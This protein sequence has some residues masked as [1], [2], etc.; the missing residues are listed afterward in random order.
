M[1]AAA[2]TGAVPDLLR[3]CRPRPRVHTPALIAHPKALSTLQNSRARATAFSRRCR[4]RSLRYSSSAARSAS[5][6]EPCVG[7]TQAVGQRVTPF[8]RMY[9]AITV[10]QSSVEI[11][12]INV[13]L[14]MSK[15]LAILAVV[16]DSGI[17][18]AT[19]PRPLMPQS[20]RELPR[21]PA[22]T[23][24]PV[25]KRLLWL[26]HGQPGIPTRRVAVVGQIIRSQ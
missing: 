5:V 1:P 7:T 4:S 9:S 21:H 11:I 8:V 15:P 6:T 23:T 14:A 19:R 26:A 16:P 25:S 10:W 24:E 22:K 12:C 20:P 17:V 3:S 2:L 18:T 13:S